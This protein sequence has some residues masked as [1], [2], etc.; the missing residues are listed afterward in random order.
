[1]ESDVANVRDEVRR[2]S[3]TKRDAVEMGSLGL[4]ALR[5]RSNGEIRF[6]VVVHPFWRTDVD[7]RTVEPFASVYRE[8]GGKDV[9][10]VDSFDAARRPVSTLDLARERPGDR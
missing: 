1:L 2:L 4:P 8:A 6:Y 10:F 5:V 7:V 9:Y 3:P